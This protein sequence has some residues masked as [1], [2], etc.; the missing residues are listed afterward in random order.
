LFTQQQEIPSGPSVT[1]A[2]NLG[3]PMSATSNPATSAST[4]PLGDADFAQLEAMLEGMRQRREATPAWEFCEGFMAALICCRRVIEPAEYWPVLLR[5]PDPWFNA[6]QERR[7]G[8]LWARRW[9]AVQLALD[10]PVAAL[11]QPSAYRP[12]LDA[13]PAPLPPGP[14]RAQAP[15]F[16]QQ[17]AEGFMAVVQAWPEEWKG[18][19]NSDARAWRAS[20]LGFVEA[21][22]HADTDAATQPAFADGDDDGDSAATVSATRMKAFSD[23]LWSVYSMR[24]MW[25]KLGPRVSAA[26]SRPRPGRNDPCSCGSGR[27]YKKC[28]G[29]AADS[30]VPAA[31]GAPMAAPPA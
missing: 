12:A 20:A 28:C 8:D 11:D 7:F 21:L 14:G 3:P 2:A 24:E 17:W 19:R 1:T 30:A 31:A 13:A 22:T 26:Q 29:P 18:P 15:S 10:T 9:Q 16:G 27:K 25:R 23:A 4:D 6:L 5:V